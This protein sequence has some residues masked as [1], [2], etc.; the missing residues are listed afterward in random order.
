MAFH[1]EIEEFVSQE[2]M[3]D[4]CNRIIR[5]IPCRCTAFFVFQYKIPECLSLVRVIC[6]EASN[7][8]NALPLPFT[9]TTV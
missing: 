2:A 3:W 8:F 1:N 7:I 9:P 4:W 5:K 6:S